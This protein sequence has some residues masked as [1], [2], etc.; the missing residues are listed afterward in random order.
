MISAVLLAFIV[1]AALC[2]VGGIIYKGLDYMEGPKVIKHAC[3]PA[4]LGCNDPDQ[5]RKGCYRAL[6]YRMATTTQGATLD[7]TWSN[8]Q[9]LG[10][11]QPSRPVAAQRFARV[12][13]GIIQ[14]RLHEVSDS[15]HQLRQL[16]AGDN[17]DDVE[18]PTHYE[19]MQRLQRPSDVKTPIR[20]E[21]L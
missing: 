14:S 12:R 13:D 11:W 5:S 20:G 1:I 4:G 15:M 8:Y 18:I 2:G 21:I 9:S 7:R 16:E 3:C 6:A 10:W 17:A 19:V